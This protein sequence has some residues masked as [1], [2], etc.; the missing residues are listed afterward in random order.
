MDENKY[1]RE[2]RALVAANKQHWRQLD[3]DHVVSYTWL[4]RFAEGAFKNARITTLRDV[5]VAIERASA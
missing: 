1:V 5:R 2:V 4:A 3:K